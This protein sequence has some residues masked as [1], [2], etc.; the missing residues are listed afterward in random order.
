M[1]QVFLGSQLRRKSCRIPSSSVEA[2]VLVDQQA[3]D[4]VEHR[5]RSCRVV[6]R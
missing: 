4:L 5:V 1:V 6:L 3:F 2:G